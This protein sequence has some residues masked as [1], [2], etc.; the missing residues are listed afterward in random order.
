MRG[1]AL[2]DRT[3]TDDRGETAGLREA[4]RRERDL[5]RSRDAHHFYVGLA[6][7]GATERFERTFKELVC[8]HIVEPTEDDSESQPNT[9]RLAFPDLRHVV[10]FSL[11]YR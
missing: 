6:D 4:F 3:E 1:V 10:S 5:E 8:H 7:A 2:D 9:Y 11:T